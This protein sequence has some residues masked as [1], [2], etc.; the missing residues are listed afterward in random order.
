MR[1]Y[2]IGIAQGLGPILPPEQ[3][4]RLTEAGRKIRFEKDEII[5]RQGEEPQLKL[6]RT[7]ECE[8]QGG[9]YNSQTLE[10]SNP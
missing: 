6:V 2:S 7:A 1:E 3:I 10:C 9:I 4:K 8:E 5:Y